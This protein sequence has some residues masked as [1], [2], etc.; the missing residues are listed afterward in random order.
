MHEELPV[1]LLLLGGGELRVLSCEGSNVELVR[2]YAE[3]ISADC[4]GGFAEVCLKGFPPVWDPPLGH[5]KHL[6]RHRLSLPSEQAAQCKIVYFWVD[7]GVHHSAVGKRA[8]SQLAGLHH[9]PC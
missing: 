4:D 7:S 3:E 6:A 8:I 9:C 1:C 2:V 5:S